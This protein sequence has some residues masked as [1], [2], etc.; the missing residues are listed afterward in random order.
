M[1]YTVDLTLILRRLF[2]MTVTERNK[3]KPSQGTLR[4]AID[5]Y[6]GSGPSSPLRAVHDEIR[7]I[8]VRWGNNFDRDTMQGSVQ[9]L[10]S[11]SLDK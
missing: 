10:I 7:S 6:K 5:V 1:A 2:D 3:G 8:V 4:T 11:R 9:L